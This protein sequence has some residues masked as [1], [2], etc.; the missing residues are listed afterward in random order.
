MNQRNDTRP[1]RGVLWAGLVLVVLA[2]CLFL[3]SPPWTPPASGLPHYSQVTS[4]RL[5][6]QLGQEVSAGDLLGRVWVADIIF[7]RCPGPCVKMTRQLAELQA[8]L[9]PDSRVTLVSLTA[10]PEFDTPEVLRAYGDRFGAK[11]PRW[12]FL[13]GR[14][15]DV[16]DLA[17]QQLLLAVDDTGPEQRTNDAD[18]FV[19]STKLVLVDPRGGVRGVFE[20]TEPE[21]RP[22]LMEAIGLLLKEGKG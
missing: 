19:H 14:K 13:S 17:I 6:N 9:P 20:G 2:L 22:R 7:T 1:L 4:F 16:Y 15:A 8:A 21:S 11:S 18:L 5:T 12:H 10:D 3:A